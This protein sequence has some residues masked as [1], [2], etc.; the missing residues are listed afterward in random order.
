MRDWEQHCP[1]CNQPMGKSGEPVGN[2]QIYR[3][4]SGHTLKALI[5]KVIK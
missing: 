5:F 4:P 2:I 3:C 1:L